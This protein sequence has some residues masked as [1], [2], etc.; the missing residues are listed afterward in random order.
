MAFSFPLNRIFYRPLIPLSHSVRWLSLTAIS[1]IITFIFLPHR[2]ENQLHLK[3]FGVRVNVCYEEERQ[4]LENLFRLFFS[5][6]LSRATMKTS[7]VLYSAMLIIICGNGRLMCHPR[8]PTSHAQV[9]RCI[10]WEWTSVPIQLDS[11]V[12]VLQISQLFTN[13]A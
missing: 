10:T 13:Y 12:M 11:G 7:S 9:A 4:I 6:S 8:V 1:Y 3:L 5:G 2:H